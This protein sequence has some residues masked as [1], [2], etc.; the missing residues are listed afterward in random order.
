MWRSCT[1]PFCVYVVAMAKPTVGVAARAVEAS[2]LCSRSSFGIT[3]RCAV[4]SRLTDKVRS[5]GPGASTT[6][7]GLR[8]HSRIQPEF[9]AEHYRHRTAGPSPPFIFLSSI[10]GFL[11][12]TPSCSRA[13]SRPTS[14]LA[15]PPRRTKTSSMPPDSPTVNSSGAC[16]RGS[17]PRVR[18]PIPR[19]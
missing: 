2:R 18:V 4:K 6:R 17:I 3:T 5:F 7:N 1:F 19:G 13:R 12:R 10:H 8:R 9:V 11:L 14:R 15:T 16:P